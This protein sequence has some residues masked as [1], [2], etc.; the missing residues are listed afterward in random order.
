MK[1][2]ALEGVADADIAVDDGMLFDALRSRFSSEVNT[3]CIGWPEQ[4]W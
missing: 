1:G 2:R 4:F 3:A